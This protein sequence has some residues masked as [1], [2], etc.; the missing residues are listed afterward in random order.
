MNDLTQAR[1][2]RAAKIAIHI[3]NRT[4]AYLADAAANISKKGF[5]R[6]EPSD[7][8]DV[9]IGSLPRVSRCRHHRA[10][11]DMAARRGAIFLARMTRE[12]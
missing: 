3:Q 7:S 5:L 2:K 9:G 6:S 12:N 4:A 10:I 1:M 11:P 8:P